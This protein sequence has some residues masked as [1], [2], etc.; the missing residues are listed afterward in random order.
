MD[1]L[2]HDSISISFMT[3]YVQ[4]LFILIEGQFEYTDQVL[5]PSH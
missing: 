2:V 5:L 4:L 1:N 3:V